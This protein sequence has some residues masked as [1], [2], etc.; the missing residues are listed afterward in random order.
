ML[1]GGCCNEVVRIVL[2]RCQRSAEF[3]HLFRPGN[4]EMGRTDGNGISRISLRDMGVIFKSNIKGEGRHV[5]EPIYVASPPALG[6][7]M[8]SDECSCA[9]LHGRAVVHACR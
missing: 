8:C 6:E 4:S 9:R 7:G 1:C 2:A 5:C 3:E